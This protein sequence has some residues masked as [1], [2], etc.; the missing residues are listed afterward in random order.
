MHI[1]YE[2][3]YERMLSLKTLNGVEE[4]FLVTCTLL[5]RYVLDARNQA[6]CDENSQTR[7]RA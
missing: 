4:I 6:T 2:Y 7:I 3:A 1:V 5:P